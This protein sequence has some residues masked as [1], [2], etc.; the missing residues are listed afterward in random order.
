[1]ISSSLRVIIRI[2]LLTL[3]TSFWLGVHFAARL[4]VLFTPGL[5]R[6]SRAFVFRNWAR[7]VG[8]IVG[9]R[10][11]IRG[12]PPP[13]PFF[14]VSNHLSYLD[15]F[16]LARN[17]GGVFVAREDLQRW[18]LFGFLSSLMNTIYIDRLNRRDTLRANDAIS[19]ALDRSEN[20]IV[21]AEAYISSGQE[22]RPFKSALL[23]SAA[24]QGLPVY[25]ATL[26]YRTP[27]DDPPA[28]VVLC[29]A[30][31]ETFGR[32]VLRLLQ[33]PHFDASVTYGDQPLS[34]TDRKILADQL[35]AAVRKNFVPI[36]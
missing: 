12:T 1:M 16:V 18:P 6:T 14:L 17:S 23:Y 13:S 25:Y 9:M 2:L 3:H 8:R 34:G 28:S 33:L 15:V 35:C 29:W 19:L 26:G 32:H 10:L 20:L 21:F 31:G 5:D 11:Q 30:H 7:G 24:Q 22:V 27:N 4:V 36:K